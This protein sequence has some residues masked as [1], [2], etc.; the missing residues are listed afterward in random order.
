MT[1]EREAATAGNLPLNPLKWRD[2]PTDSSHLGSVS[3]HSTAI[4]AFSIT[5]SVLFCNSAFL[6]LKHNLNK[7]MFKFLRIIFS[8]T[9]FRGAQNLP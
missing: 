5:S 2:V 8:M 7:L 9:G 3:A 1:T 6:K 4:L